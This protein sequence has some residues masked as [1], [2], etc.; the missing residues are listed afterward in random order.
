MKDRGP[1]PQENSMTKDPQFLRDLEGKVAIVTG[2]ASGIGRA[3][4]ELT[5]A[6]GAVVV[7][8]DIKPAVQELSRADGRIV[9]FVGDVSQED[10]AKRVVALAVERFGKLD[11]LVNNAARIIYKHVADMTLDEWN[12][13]LS[14]KL[15]GVFLHSRGPG[16]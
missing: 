16:R 10:T 9:P 14:V 6:R 4:V 3:T 5:E 11:I 15:M 1:S 8:E 7:A 2:A 12:G 13:I